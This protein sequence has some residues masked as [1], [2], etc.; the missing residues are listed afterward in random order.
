VPID[1]EELHGLG[2]LARL[3]Q[4]IQTVGSA[5]FSRASAIRLPEGHTVSDQAG[6]RIHPEPLRGIGRV[7]SIPAVRMAAMSSRSSIFNLSARKD[8]RINAGRIPSLLSTKL[9]SAFH[10]RCVGKLAA[11]ALSARAGHALIYFIR[12]GFPSGSNIDLITAT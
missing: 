12:G 7:G 2:A 8:S 1:L 10:A 9:A 6:N 11:G 4:G 3:D 5:S